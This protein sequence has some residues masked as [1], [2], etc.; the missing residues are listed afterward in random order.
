[1]M[2]TDTIYSLFCIVVMIV[3]TTILYQA[4][5]HHDKKSII[6]VCIIL[7]IA[8]GDKVYRDRETSFI[9]GIIK[10]YKNDN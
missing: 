4:V 6:I 1:M 3:A 7:A 5:Y 10:G 9:Y 8:Y 2:T